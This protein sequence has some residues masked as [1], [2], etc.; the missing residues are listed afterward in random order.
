VRAPK[1]IAKRIAGIRIQQPWQSAALEEAADIPVPDEEIVCR[2]E[3]VTAGELRALIR[4]GYRDLNEIKAVTRAM[5]GAC[6]A[7]TCTNLIL[8][9]FREEGVPLQEVTANV[10]RPLF[11]EV[12]LG[13]FAGWP[14]TEDEEA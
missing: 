8:R 4:K 2:C 7:K 6:G 9:L 12:P 14:M 10:K 3:R 11:V 1:A 5:M 13:V